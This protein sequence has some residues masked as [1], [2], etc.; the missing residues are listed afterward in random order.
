MLAGFLATVGMGLGVNLA[1]YALGALGVFSPEV[2]LVQLIR[3]AAAEYADG[4]GPRMVAQL[5]LLIF[6]LNML[7]AVVYAWVAEGRLPGALWAEGLLFS[8]LPLAFSVF[9]LLPALGGGTVGLG[10]GAGLV[11]LVG[12]LFRNALFGIGLG[13]WY[14]LLLGAREGARRSSAV[15]PVV[16]R[17]ARRSDAP[18]RSG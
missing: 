1:L 2:A 14:A 5:A 13:A 10:L 12:E 3:T 8:V 17:R 16:S 9:L 7:W 15:E 6:L 18:D 11:P 4:S